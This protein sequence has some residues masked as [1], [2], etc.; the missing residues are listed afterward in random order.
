MKIILYLFFL[1]VTFFSSLSKTSKRKSHYSSY[2]DSTELFN[3]LPT[4]LLSANDNQL[5]NYFMDSSF[6]RFSST[7][8][9]KLIIDYDKVYGRMMDNT[10][11][12][13]I[14]QR[15]LFFEKSLILSKTEIPIVEYMKWSDFSERIEIWPSGLVVV[16]RN[17][18][19]SHI[20]LDFKS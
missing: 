16:F 2:S 13:T 12:K 18:K 5:S 11:I 14:S 15:I 4:F 7:I 8:N 6:R 10:T 19:L 3:R 1:P 9:G 20:W 17:N